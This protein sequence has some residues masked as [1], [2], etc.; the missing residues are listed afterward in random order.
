MTSRFVKKEE[1]VDEEQGYYLADIRYEKEFTNPYNLRDDYK[2]SVWWVLRPYLQ[3][4]A[5]T[6]E[7]PPVDPLEENFAQ[8]SS[9]QI[10]CYEYLTSRYERIPIRSR[11]T[12]SALKT[13][14]LYDA[15]VEKIRDPI[16]ER[17]SN[18][19]GC[20]IKSKTQFN[21]WIRMVFGGDVINKKNWRVYIK[22][23]P[24]W[25][26]AQPRWDD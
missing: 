1:D 10:P 17:W 22:E 20:A 24:E 7:L 5:N 15:A 3:E 16:T 8:E 23:R 11:S 6:G 4:Y 26:S 9:E 25:R 2:L 21:S 12:A 19:C 18:R 13:K 14:D